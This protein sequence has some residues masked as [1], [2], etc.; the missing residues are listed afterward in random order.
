MNFNFDGLT[1]MQKFEDIMQVANRTWFNNIQ[2]G[3]DFEVKLKPK[4][5][6]RPGTIAATVTLGV[7][8][9][10]GPMPARSHTPVPSPPVS[11]QAALKHR[12]HHTT[13]RPGSAAAHVH[14]Q[15]VG[16]AVSTPHDPTSPRRL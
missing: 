9:A 7:S 16:R 6:C 11:H 12:C 13:Y 15:V 5:H 10:H 3:F 14:H 2:I 1:C 4:S 8:L